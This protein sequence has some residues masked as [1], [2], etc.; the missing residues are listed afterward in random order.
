MNWK[1]RYWILSAALLLGIITPLG[2][3]DEP[4]STSSL[5]IAN[6]LFPTAQNKVVEGDRSAKIPNEES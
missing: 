2:C 4:R 1:V 5:E 6:T 3:A